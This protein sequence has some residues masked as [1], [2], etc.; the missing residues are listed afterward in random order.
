[1]TDIVDE[2]PDIPRPLALD[3]HRVDRDDRED[4]T[5]EDHRTRAQLLARALDESCDY[6][7]Q[8]WQTMAATRVYLHDHFPD[9]PDD[10]AEWTRWR[11]A[12]AAVVAVLCSPKGDS[13]FGASQARLI[14][15]HRR[16]S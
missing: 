13:G 10:D 1:M 7:T 4:F 12:Y 6:A 14:A 8:L 16:S 9:D 11:A 3:S 5:A 2:M 15:Q